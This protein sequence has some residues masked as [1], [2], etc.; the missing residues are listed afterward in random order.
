M[1]NSIMQSHER[2]SRQVR[3]KVLSQETLLDALTNQL[4][5]KLP[6]IPI[7]VLERRLKVHVRFEFCCEKGQENTEILVLVSK[8]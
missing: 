5:D 2:Q 7:D 3:V 1:Q 4:T 8:K 6:V